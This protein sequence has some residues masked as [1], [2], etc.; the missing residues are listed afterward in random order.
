MTRVWEL[1]DGRVVRDLRSVAH[2]Y[3][4]YGAFTVTLTVTDRQGAT[5]SLSLLRAG[6]APRAEPGHD[7][8]RHVRAGDAARRAGRHSRLVVGGDGF[9]EYHDETGSGRVV[10]RGH[11]TMRCCASVVAIFRFDSI[12]EAHP[13]WSAR[14]GEWTA[15][16][17]VVLLAGSELGISFVQSMHAEG[18]EDG[19]YG[20]N[21]TVIRCRRHRREA[22]SP[23]CATGGFT[24]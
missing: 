14:D 1:G 8:E 2:T 22:R 3:A 24:S 19:N 10:H 7:P 5:S 6:R 16:A 20:A 15:S 11:W 23:S 17:L 13:E 21:P 12:A 4:A 9:F 18:F